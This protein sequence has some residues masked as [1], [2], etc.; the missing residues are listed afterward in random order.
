MSRTERLRLKMQESGLDALIVTSELNQRYLSGYHFTDGLLLITEKHAWL[1][2]DFRYYEDAQGKAFTEYKVVMPDSRRAFVSGVFEEDAVKRVGFENEVMSCA[3]LERYKK[4]YDHVKFVGIDHMLEDLREMKGE[5]EISLMASAQE[6]ADKAFSLLLNVMHPEMTEID[7]ALE[8]ELQMRRLGAEGTAFE[9][10]AVSGDA[11][12]LPHG[13]PRNAKLKRGFLTMDFGA[14]YQGYLSDMTRTVSIGA[15]DAEMKRLYDTVLRA[16][17]AGLESIRP[18]ADC[19]SCDRV[20]RDIIDGAGYEGCFGHSLGHGVGLFIH[21][22]PRLSRAGAG[23]RL[24][25]GHV[26]TV[27]PGIYVFGKHGCRIEDMVA[28]TEDGYRN[29]ASTTKELLELF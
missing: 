13:K 18:G 15:A 4:A 23:K 26:V 10:I 22:A 9:T 7:V 6:I 2:T 29:F 12:A 5:D 17:L 20:A 25:P 3:E 11:S 24:A 14:C 21:E 19:A 1:I 16:Q 8:L 27:E 28:V